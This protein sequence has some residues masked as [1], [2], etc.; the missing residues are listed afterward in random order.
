MTTEQWQHFEAKY[1]QAIKDEKKS[2][3][4]MDSEVL[5]AY[6]KYLLE[7]KGNL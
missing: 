6:A 3:N 7:W 4:F 2:F 5:V 1:N